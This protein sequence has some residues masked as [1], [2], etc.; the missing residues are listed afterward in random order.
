MATAK[1]NALV[2]LDQ[3]IAHFAGRLDTASCGDI[4]AA[5]RIV[6]AAYL[7]EDTEEIEPE[8][9]AEDPM[10]DEHG[11]TEAQYLTRVDAPYEPQPVEHT[12]TD[13]GF[14]PKSE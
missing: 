9:V 1:Q 14:D 11:L 12:E 7:A 8:P 10:T 3:G 13:L 4:A 6:R 5:L 2:Q